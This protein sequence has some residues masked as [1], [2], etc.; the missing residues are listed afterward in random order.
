MFYLNLFGNGNSVRWYGDNSV[1]AKD[2]LEKYKYCGSMYY[3]GNTP[4]LARISNAQ[5]AT[6]EYRWVVQI[7]RTNVQKDKTQEMTGCTGSII[8]ER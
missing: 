4:S 6:K 2:H 3:V 7:V 8:T 1:I 5:D